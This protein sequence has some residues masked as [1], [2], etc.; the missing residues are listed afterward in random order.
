M[1]A[2]NKNPEDRQQSCDVFLQQL[3][4]KSDVSS[5]QI[6]KTP[7]KKPTDQQKLPGSGSNSILK[8]VYGIVGYINGGMII[9]SLIIASYLLLDNVNEFQCY[10]D[11]YTY[12]RN[13]NYPQAIKSFTKCLNKDQND[14]KSRFYRSWSHYLLG[15]YSIALTDANTLIKK[16]GN[17][18]DYNLRG[19]VHYGLS[20]S[21]KAIADFTTAIS[22]GRNDSQVYNGRAWS[23]YHEKKYSN[24]STDFNKAISIS[25]KFDN[26]YYGRA[27]TRW[28]SGNRYGAMSDM[29][30]AI[31]LDSLNSEYFIYR[32]LFFQ[33]MNNLR[34]A[35]RDWKKA[36]FLES[37]DADYY[38]DKYCK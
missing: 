21:K 38:I 36:K 24:A 32:G 29:S 13:K 18:D 35:C 11:G 25:P 19:W 14:H 10:D 33:D 26:S 31:K 30:K 37:E 2:L 23:F 5:V 27:L 16:R 1:M 22:K 3:E 12:Y 6:K 28:D 20:K 8:W 34:N 7:V 4:G 15:D 17:A 9:I